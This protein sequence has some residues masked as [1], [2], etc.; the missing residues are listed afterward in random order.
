MRFKVCLEIT[1]NWIFCVNYTNLGYSGRKKYHFVHDVFY[2]KM[3]DYK[4]LVKFLMASGIKQNY[5]FIVFFAV[6]MFV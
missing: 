3:S 2:Q 6:Q 4:Y 1:T 5:S